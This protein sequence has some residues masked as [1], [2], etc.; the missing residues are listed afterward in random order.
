M[1]I[2][3]EAGRQLAVTDLNGA[4]LRALRVLGSAGMIPS[5][6]EPAAAGGQNPATSE[7][8]PAGG[9]GVLVERDFTRPPRKAALKQPRQGTP[10][11]RTAR[12]ATKAS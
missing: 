3:D 9:Q 4:E 8:G 12:P 11:A 10:A 7:K 1:M 5:P 6:D 2:T